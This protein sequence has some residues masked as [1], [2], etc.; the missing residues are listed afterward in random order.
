[1]TSSSGRSYAFVGS[2]TTLERNASGV[3]ISSFAVGPTGEWTL[4]SEAGQL[5]NPSYLVCCPDRGVLY[6]VH[7]D[8]REVSA[9]RIHNDG[10]LTAINTKTTHGSNPVH[11]AL[12]PD[13]RYVIVANYGTG[14]VS[15]LPVGDDG[16]LGDAVCVQELKGPPGPHRVEQPS[17]RPHQVVFDSTGRFLLVPD[18]GLDRT[19]VFRFDA[20][21]GAVE[22]H[23]FAWCGARSGAGPR[24]LV[25][26]RSLGVIYVVNE[27]DCTITTYAW[28]GE[29][30]YL[31]PRQIVPALPDWY[32][33]NGS[34]AA[35]VLDE[36]HD[37]LYVSIRHQNSVCTYRTDP[38]SGLLSQPS[39]ASVDGLQPRFISLG[40]GAPEL[41]VANELS[42][43][44][45]AIRLPAEGDSFEFGNSA[46]LRRAD[47]R[48]PVCIARY[49]LTDSAT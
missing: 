41:L 9:L 30:G 28:D 15:S 4:V 5:L 22:P 45:R 2:R 20:A 32:T 34:A 35:I 16:S 36:E 1:M 19:W 44:I 24:H 10:S 13:G 23:S 46:S 25:E 40:E 6:T 43:E 8:S 18:K 17:S 21:S 29:R 37:R 27:L 39:W 48:N 14:S 3:G 12:S 7:G 11:L 38:E 47:V 42:G 26:H 49:S 31:E 33:G